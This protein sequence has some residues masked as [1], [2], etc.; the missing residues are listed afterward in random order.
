VNEETAG[1]VGCEPPAPSSTSPALADWEAYARKLEDAIC[2]HR[3]SVMSLGLHGNSRG[4]LVWGGQYDAR[5]WAVVGLPDRPHN[6]PPNATERG[7]PTSS[8][9]KGSAQ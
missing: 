9:K 7:T 3:Q 4:E 5:L 1:E 8:W 2:Y 6:D